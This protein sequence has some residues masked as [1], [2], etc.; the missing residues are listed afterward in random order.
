M[1][2]EDEIIEGNMLIA[3]FMSVSQVSAENGHFYYVN[4]DSYKEL[5]YHSSW[6]WLMPVVE[7][8]NKMNAAIVINPHNVNITTHVIDHLLQDDS[9][10]KQY[11]FKPSGH[12]YTPI[13]AVWQCVVEFIKWYNEKN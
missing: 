12:N 6:D 2:T 9:Y 1:K 10:L 4:G 13:E 3:E 11:F 7:K 5:R 8:I